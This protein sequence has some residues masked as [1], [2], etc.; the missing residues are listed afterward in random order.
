MNFQVQTIL[1]VGSIAD[2]QCINQDNLL[3]TLIQIE[4]KLGK[5]VRLNCILKKS[6]MSETTKFEGKILEFR[7]ITGKD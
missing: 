6:D 2:K 3:S 5:F 1:S 7:W 4:Y